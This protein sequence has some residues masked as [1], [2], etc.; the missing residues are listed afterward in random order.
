MRSIANKGTALFEDGGALR[1][2]HSLSGVVEILEGVDQSIVLRCD[3]SWIGAFGEGDWYARLA[4]E[5]L[6]DEFVEFVYEIVSVWRTRT[7]NNRTVQALAAALLFWRRFPPRDAEIGNKGSV[8]ITT[9]YC[10]WSCG[11][12]CDKRE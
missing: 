3:G 1:A 5:T 7:L 8:D 9:D 10:A 4:S 6:R 11:G 2:S 12:A